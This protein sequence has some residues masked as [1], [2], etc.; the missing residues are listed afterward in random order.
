MSVHE[1]IKPQVELQCNNKLNSGL[2]SCDSIEGKIQP[3]DTNLGKII[4]DRLDE[5]R[6]TQSWLAEQV[7]VSN[8]AVTKWIATGK[9][10]RVN[11]VKIAQVLKIST[12]VLLGAADK[13]QNIASI[14]NTEKGPDIKGEYPLI[15]WVQAGVW[16]DIVDTFNVGEAEAVFACPKKCSSSTFMLRV[17]GPS[18]EPKYSDGDLIYVDPSVQY[19]HGKNVIVK[20]TGSQEAT[21]KNLVIDGEKMW[22]KPLNPSWPE[23][24]IQ[25]DS[26]ALIVGV[27]IGKY[28]PD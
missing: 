7:G 24:V 8:N 27:V 9:V 23:Q 1:P 21:F 19:A 15:S 2:L 25:L 10:S 11:A 28:V 12:D 3:M 22:L 26:D 14:G 18:M 16:M 20:L 4:K 17:R 13:N 6:Q 5:L